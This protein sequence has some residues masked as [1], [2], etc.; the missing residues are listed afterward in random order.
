[1]S[2]LSG[3]DG[4]FADDDG[5]APPEAAAALAAFAAG[6]GSEH[7]A[8]TALARSRLLVPLV[9]QVAGPGPGESCDASP[10]AGPA[11]G[12]RAS[13]PHASTAHASTAPARA[14]STH[15]S[16]TSARGSTAHASSTHASTTSARGS[17]AH[18]SSTHAS[19][20]PG[21][22]KTSSLAVPELIG[23]D[24]RPAL[25]VFTSTEALARW[26]PGARPVPTPAERVW[27]AAA[28]GP[29]AVVID[30]AGPVMLAVE[31]ARLAALAAGQAVPLLHQDPDIW[32]AAAVALAAV[33]PGIR[34]RLLPGGA[35]LDLVLELATG[36]RE[37]DLDPEAAGAA[38]LTSLAGRL[39]RGISV[40]TS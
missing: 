6:D 21:P 37:P 40:V 31:G 27:Q 32:R 18:A 23:R 35:E 39:R 11:E 25:A 7:A 24:G 1:V 22:E 36:P 33:A 10:Q 13:S 19:T 20:A 12:A 28:S 34:F 29:G 3:G 38:V 17:T 4:R 16:T 30:I 5:S 9:A 8:L 15:A 26:Q 2:L 14:S